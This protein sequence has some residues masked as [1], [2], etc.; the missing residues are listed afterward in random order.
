MLLNSKCFFHVC[1]LLE[2]ST[3][4]LHHLIA[5]DHPIS[6]INFAF[7]KVFTPKRKPQS[8]DVIV[9]T[10]T[11]NRKHHYSE[12]IIKNITKNTTENLRSVFGETSVIVGT[13]QPKWLRDMLARSKFSLRHVT[14]RSAKGLGYCARTCKY[15]RVGYIVSSSSFSFGEQIFT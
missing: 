12:Y 13:R 14:R 6:A 15:H 11:L 2:Y 7:T 8:D 10:S 1:L 5:R 9:L 4:T 3:H